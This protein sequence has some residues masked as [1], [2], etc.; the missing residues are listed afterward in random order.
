MPSQP[1]TRS[2]DRSSSSSSSSATMKQSRISMTPSR[3]IAR[4]KQEGLAQNT[5]SSNTIRKYQSSD[6][7]YRVKKGEHKSNSGAPVANERESK[8]QDRKSAKVNPIARATEPQQRTQTVYDRLKQMQDD[9]DARVEQMRHIRLERETAGRNSTNFPSNS[10]NTENRPKDYS[11]N[12]A[13]LMALKKS[14]GAERVQTEKLRASC[15]ALSDRNARRSPSKLTQYR[16]AAA[17]GV[18]KNPRKEKN[19]MAVVDR[20]YHNAY[21]KEEDVQEEGNE[22]M[23][24]SPDQHQHQRSS[25]SKKTF[26]PRCVTTGII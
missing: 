10:S 18:K 1:K 26:S 14:R 16:E 3:T 22:D 2:S 13:H 21:M 23:N 24:H 4:K 20:L 19:S 9:W 7:Y 11:K 5:I 12:K 17:S 25:K 15:T 8:L 6:A